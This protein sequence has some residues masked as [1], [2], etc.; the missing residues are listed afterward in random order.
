MIA[1][2]FV[3]IS[4]SISE[5]KKHQAAVTKLRFSW[6]SRNPVCYAKFYSR[7]ASGC[8]SCLRFYWQRD[9]NARAQ[10]RFQRVVNRLAILPPFNGH[11]PLWEPE[12]DC[13]MQS[14]SR[15]MLWASTWAIAASVVLLASC[16]VFQPVID[17]VPVGSLEQ[18]VVFYLGDTFRQRQEF[19]VTA[20]TVVEEQSD[21]STRA[22]WILEGG[23]RLRYITYGAKYPDLKESRRPLRLRRGKRYEVFVYTSTG[24]KSVDV[25]AFRVDENGNVKQIP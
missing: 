15:Y 5:D 11:F 8:D 7:I 20:V 4:Q 25:F 2:N 3:V 6:E 16:S 23:Q 19:T 18:G 12:I 14:N 13:K 17:V 21:G 22:I 1:T 24:A 10:G 9:R